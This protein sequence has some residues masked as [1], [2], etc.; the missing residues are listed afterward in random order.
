MIFDEFQQGIIARLESDAWFTQDVP[1]LIFP[2]EDPDE[3]TDE[4]ASFLNKK[5]NDALNSAG[6]AIVVS[7]V[8][9]RHTSEMRD[10]F[11]VECSVVVFENRQKAR[12]A[13]TGARRS[14]R[15]AAVKVHGRLQRY[16]I[17]IEDDDGVRVDPFDFLN[18][19]SS[20]FIGEEGGTKVR[21]VVVRS[22]IP[23]RIVGYS[24]ADEVGFYLVDEEGQELEVSPVN[25]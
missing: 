17:P 14:G 24:L 15:D 11:Q 7:E 22:R 8:D 12:K 13:S 9:Y 16:R 4:T 5:L 20:E 3:I 19:E 1:I 21:V 23:I 18:I 10:M 25:P 6:V 2:E